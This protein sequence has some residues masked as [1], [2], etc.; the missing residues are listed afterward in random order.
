[1]LGCQIFTIA[2]AEPTFTT[3]VVKV[4]QSIQSPNAL[5]KR[6]YADAVSKFENLNIKISY[7]DFYDMIANNKNSDFLLLLIADK[8]AE[9]G[10]FDLSNLAFSKVEDCDISSLNSNNIKRFYFPKK[11]M[12]R[13]DTITLGEYYSNINYNDQAKEAVDEL[14]KNTKYLSEYDYANYL[15]ALGYYN[16][17][18]IPAAEKFIEIASKQ[19]PENINYKILKSKIIALSKKP[20]KAK[21]EL[22]EINKEDIAL[23]G[24]NNKI[25]SANEY[26]KYQTAKKSYE[27]DFYLGDYYFIEGDYQK[28]IKTLLSSISK[29]KIINAKA[30]AILSRCYYETGEYDKA[31]DCA[32]KSYK[33]T[34]NNS[35]SLMTLGDIELRNGRFKQALKYYKTA[36]NHT[37]DK[38]MTAVKIAM[39]YSKLSNS[40]RANEVY[41]SILEKTDKSYIAYYQVGLSNPLKETEYLKKSVEINPKFQEGWIDLARV[42]IEKGNLDLADKYLS[43]ANYIDDSNF[44]YYYYQSLLKKKQSELNNTSSA[45]S[46]IDNLAESNY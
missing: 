30:Y 29:N 46:I 39:T 24:L 4:E 32:H 28:A 27:K 12:T 20:Q 31:L 11:L 15:M 26:V 8:T 36:K 5:F 43:N 7:V 38:T 22:K 2:N 10:F 3:D 40:K 18:N 9:L 13:T 33:I 35:N 45:Y 1:M 16:L 34:K 19:N 6:E 14:S 23:S 44:R 41:Q 42:M 37:D 25:K 17:N 21:K